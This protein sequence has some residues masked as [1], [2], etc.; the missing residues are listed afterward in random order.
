MKNK[1]GMWC[2]AYGIDP[3][4]L[5]EPAVQFPLD[6]HDPVDTLR[7]VQSK[8]YGYVLDP[9]RGIDREA[10]EPTAKLQFLGLFG[11]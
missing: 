2:V 5:D 9:K 10:F 8:H 1:L 6:D 7:A 11:R 3:K 4:V